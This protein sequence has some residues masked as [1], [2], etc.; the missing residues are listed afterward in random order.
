M[1]ALAE[2]MDVG[3]N[4]CALVTGAGSGLGREVAIELSRRGCAVAAL[5]INGKSADE[6]V[7]QCCEAG[8]KALAIAD[9]LTRERGPE[10]AVQTVVRTWAR[11]DI[12]VNNAGYGAIEP[13]LG[14]TAAL[15]HKTLS[16]NV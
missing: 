15:W 14:M 12:L 1:E 5:D 16:L 13:F 11:L 7:A 6:T 9:D 3:T 2:P 8:G 4:R 10:D